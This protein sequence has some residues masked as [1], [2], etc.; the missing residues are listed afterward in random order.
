MRKRRHDIKKN[1]REQRKTQKPLTLSFYKNNNHINQKILKNKVNP[2]FA[3]K[4]DSIFAENQ[5]LTQFE[6]FMQLNLQKLEFNLE[7]YN[8]DYLQKSRQAA[9]VNK[10]TKKKKKKKN[11]STIDNKDEVEGT[12]LRKN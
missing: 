5:Q 9:P 11:H 1:L 10:K 8:L 7:H 2:K 4:R 3:M 12:K 6:V